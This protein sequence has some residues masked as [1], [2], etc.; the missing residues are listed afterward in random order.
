MNALD[1][2]DLEFRIAKSNRD[3]PWAMRLLCTLTAPWPDGFAPCEGELYELYSGATKPRRSRLRLTIIYLE[4][5]GA[6]GI[7]RLDRLF[8]QPLFKIVPVDRRQM[9]VAEQAYER[10]RRGRH[11][12][13]TARKV[14]PD[15][16]C[17]LKPR[18]FAFP[19]PFP[20]NNVRKDALFPLSGR[21]RLLWRRPVGTRKGKGMQGT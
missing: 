17:F 19:N 11:L 14:S 16:P 9:A 10:F 7:L 4:K 1:W 6:D 15:L 8:E 18:G 13:R 3:A 20:C 12:N 2:D 5:L 21:W